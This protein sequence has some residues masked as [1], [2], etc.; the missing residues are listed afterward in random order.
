M[1]NQE[2]RLSAARQRRNQIES[3]RE[4][5]TR[6]VHSERGNIAQ[7]A[8]QMGYSHSIARAALWDLGLWPMV[9]RYQQE[10]KVKTNVWLRH[11]IVRCD[12]KVLRIAKLRG[13]SFQSTRTM[14]VRRGLWPL[15]EKMRFQ[16]A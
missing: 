7:I 13:K 2:Y 15:V 11:L 16:R 14:I 10:D 8:K 4:D 1:R 3:E 5:W 6:L 12:G 9:Q